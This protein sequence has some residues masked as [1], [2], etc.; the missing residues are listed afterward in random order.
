MIPIFVRTKYTGLMAEVAKGTSVRAWRR[1]TKAAHELAGKLW[2]A[3][4]LPKHFKRMARSRYGYQPRKER[5]KAR[6]ARQQRHGLIEG[7]GDQDLVYTGKLR[8]MAL[9]MA[10][11]KGYPTRAKVILDLPSYA[12]INTFG[13]RPNLAAEVLAVTPDEAAQLS[14]VIEREIDAGLKALKTTATTDTAKG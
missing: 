14:L 8:D 10:T 4:M 1:I 7:F 9:R 5:Y 6:K 12:R 13:G 2:H 3:L 11:V